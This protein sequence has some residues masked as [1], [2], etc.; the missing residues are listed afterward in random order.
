MEQVHRNDRAEAMTMARV[1]GAPAPDCV[2]QD[3]HGAPVRLSEL[4]DKAPRATVL[5]FL[6]EFG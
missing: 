6:R 5:V 1:P 2:V 4:W 3:E